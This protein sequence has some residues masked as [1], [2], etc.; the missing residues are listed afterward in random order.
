MNELAQLWGT[1]SV[2]D[3]NRPNAFVAELGLFDT[4]VVPVQPTD[5]G[6]KWAGE[7]DG[8]A[9]ERLLSL[10]PDDRLMR[11]SW[12]ERQRGEWARRARAEEAGE[13]VIAIQQER[14]EYVAQGGT[15]TDYDAEPFH[16]T[17]QVLQD[18]VDAERERA[19]IKGMPQV[20]VTVIPAYNGPGQFVDEEGSPGPRADAVA[21]EPAQ[22]R[23]LRAFQWEFFAPADEVGDGRR[24]KHEDL[25]KAALDLA[26]LPEV[27]AHRQAFR[28]WTSIEATRGTDPVQARAK[29]EAMLEAYATAVKASGIP[30][31]VRWGC[32]IVELAA[33][34]AAV[35]MPWFGVV[36]PLLKLGGMA[37]A[38]RLGA[39]GKPDPA[40][41]PAALIHGLRGAFDAVE[42]TGLA[43]QESPLLPLEKFWPGGTAAL[44]L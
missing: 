33:S 4:L 44:Y 16:V 41:R 6:G 37:G 5:G 23:L 27:Q 34:A 8:V 43:P 14:E 21:A 18:F 2:Q 38:E 39:A 32:G 11:V 40:V 31:A 42:P 17:R 1:V 26:A 19:L 25:I 20:P 24:R 35:K 3:H 12:D 10:I 30:V 36:G 15:A 7:W 29:M 28:T 9:Q 22:E 13:D